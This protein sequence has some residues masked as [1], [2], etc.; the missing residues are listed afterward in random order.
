MP[1][2]RC[3][4]QN[5]A[6]GMGHNWLRSS[7][8]LYR[9]MSTAL[10][11]YLTTRELAELLRIKERKVYDLVASGTVPCTRATGKL[12]FARATIEAWLESSQTGPTGAPSAQHLPEVFL[13]SHDPLLEWALKESDCAIASNFG[14]SL[15]GLER[16]ANA[17]GIASALHLFEPGDDQWNVGAISSQF[18]GQAVVLI[19]FCWRER[20]LI[21]QPDQSHSITCVADLADRRVVARQ[22]ETG[23][24]RL[25]KQLLDQAGIDIKRLQFTMAAHS[26]TEAASAVLEGLADAALGLR[27]LA[28]RYRLA[29][30]PLMR[31]RFDL[32][33]DRRAWFEPPL[34]TFL[35][36]CA[37]P[38]F[39]DKA[40]SLPGYEVQ[41][42][43]KVHFNG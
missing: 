19:E 37:S 36:F 1:C 42:F 22:P 9:I 15:D 23:S 2:C 16:F 8:R 7:A 17:K 5:R 6:T 21:L 43:G 34:Q 12:L 31:E 4:H 25:L 27:A 26:E 14:G 40:A 41:G 32:L 10:S 33:I 20:G 13:G 28:E 35:H 38:A 30:V 24:Q 11:D 39:A 18:T 3:R 29:F